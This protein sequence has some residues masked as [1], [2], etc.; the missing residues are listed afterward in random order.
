M[1]DERDKNLFKGMGWI[2]GITI[3][4]AV[5]LLILFLWHQ[6]FDT[7]LSV[8]TGIFGTYGDFVGGVLGTIIALY[9]AYLLIK[10]LQ[11][12]TTINKD[13]EKTNA[14]V[15]TTNESIV[16][17]NKKAD[18][19]AQRQYYQNELQIFDGKFSRFFDAY[20][21]AIGAYYHEP[22]RGRAAFEIIAHFFIDTNF[23]NNNDYKRRTLSAVDD[24]LEFYSAHRTE[25][26][27][28]LRMLYLLVTLISNSELEEDDKVEFAKLVRGQMSNAEM[29]I[30]R[31]NCLSPYGEKMRPFCNQ[32]NLTKHLSVT[33]LLEFKAYRRTIEEVA[34]DESSKLL[35]GLD[36]MFISLRKRITK[37]LYDGNPATDEYKTSHSYTIQ[38]DFTSP[39]KQTFLLE[40]KKD[41]DVGRRGGG[42]RVSPDE[43]A[44]DKLDENLLVSMF[45]DFMSELFVM[46]NFETYNEGIEIRQQGITV[47]TD[48]ELSFKIRATNNKRL[49]LTTIQRE[50]RDN[51][52]VELE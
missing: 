44:L 40:L 17:A 32:Y 33:S 7:N 22:N 52:V 45:K 51:P 16:A 38:L 12:Q 23:D 29:L 50:K 21:A 47:N 15:V 28:H 25:M 46:S 36:V 35:S 4:V 31:Y 20:Q 2:I 6:T 14:S 8:D 10:T 43:I 11:N 5:L 27:V 26:S 9:S 48:H 34:P 37:M 18:F 19:A 41:K 39:D 1:A 3:G 30:V 24:Y 49:V 13:I 42:I